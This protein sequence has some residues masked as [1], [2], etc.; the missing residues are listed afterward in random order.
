MYVLSA[1]VGSTSLKFKL[2]D[3]PQETAICE[4]KAERIGSADQAAYTYKN[5]LTGAEIAKQNMGITGFGEGIQMF[6]NDLLGEK[7]V[8]RN[9]HEL[10]GVGYKAVLSM[11]YY[12]VHLVDDDLLEALKEADFLSPT[13]TMPYLN[14]IA[15]FREILPDTPMVCSFETAFHETIPQY[16]RIYAIPYEWTEK[17][18][19]VRRGYHGA[20]HSY[21][22]Y[23]IG[24]RMNGT[25]K[26]ISCHLG[27][28]SSM[29]AVLN[30]K[31]IDV[32]FG[33]SLQNGLCHG[34]RIGDTDP[35]IIPYLQRQKIDDDEIY[36]Q[37]INHSGLYGIS[38]ISDD[39]REVKAAAQKGNERARLALDYF[40]DGIVRYFGSFY[41]ELGGLDHLVFTGGI[42]EN[43]AS[44]RAAVVRKLSVFRL[45]ID[46][47]KNDNTRTARIIST[48][49]SSAYIW[50]LPTNEELMIAR[51]VYKTIAL[52]SAEA[53]A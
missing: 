5:C 39:M 45:Q 6:L 36:D 44:I 1:N 10:S 17:Y 30:G 8:L 2:F 21:I 16:R 50:V 20:S 14:A 12:G 33:F 23:E 41:A 3:M 52:K 32:S 24:K 4:A 34:K 31:S 48:E 51:A 18:G 49:K 22:A 38:G 42:G 53:K 47:F 15:Q 37:L 25:G 19:I 43:D 29:C 35:Y 40:I 7:G 9:I 27:G 46:E 13:H 28:S 11:G 26:L